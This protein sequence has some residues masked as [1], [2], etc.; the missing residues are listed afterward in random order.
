MNFENT[1]NLFENISMASLIST[2]PTV[3][4]LLLKDISKSTIP[5]LV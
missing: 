4:I 1:V 5:G 2:V 3:R